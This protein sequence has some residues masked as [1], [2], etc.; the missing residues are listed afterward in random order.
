[1]NLVERAKNVL[2]SPKSEWEVIKNESM[3]ISQIF[4]Q[5]VV[6]LAAIP[7]IA[8]FIGYSFVGH[9]YGF[10]TFKV[11]IGDGIIWA[12]VTYI[13]SL[14][15][16]YVVAFI[17]DVL[18]P[19]FGG[20]KDMVASVKAVAF[21]YTAS[22][23][24]GIFSIIPVLSFLTLIAGIYSLY[25]FFLGLKALKNVPPEKYAGYFVVVIIVTIVVYVVIGLITSAIAFGGMAAY[26]FN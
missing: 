2:F 21:A 17:A 7:A 12:V 24:G 23:V 20:T 26:N 13:L 1:M 16:V 9:S 18:A 15:G 14:V 5:Y 8:G 22:W 4:T 11:P 10:G 6:I 25:L 3:T 19:N